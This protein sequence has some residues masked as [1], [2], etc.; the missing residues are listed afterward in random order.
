MRVLPYL[1][2]LLMLALAACEEEFNYEPQSVDIT[3]KLVVDCWLTDLPETQYVHLQ[4]SRSV[5][6]AEKA[7]EA[8]TG[9]EVRL[10]DDEGEILLAEATPGSYATPDGWQAEAGNFYSLIIFWEGS[11][12]TSF[13]YMEPAQDFDVVELIPANELANNPGQDLDDW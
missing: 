12:W 3:Q 13:A 4:K 2:L 7:P 6:D 10:V 1:L 9:A 11:T 5:E 8:I